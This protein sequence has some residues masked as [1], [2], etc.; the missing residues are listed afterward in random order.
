M[1][2]VGR[3]EGVVGAKGCNCCVGGCCNEYNCEGR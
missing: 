2:V 3:G 1:R